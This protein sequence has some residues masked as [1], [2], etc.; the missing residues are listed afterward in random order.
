M[1]EDR[2]NV[3]P[4]FQNSAPHFTYINY[5]NNHQALCF[6]H[7]IPKYEIFKNFD[8]LVRNLFL[9]MKNSSVK[10]VKQVKLL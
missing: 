7:L 5:Q 1:A 10:Q 6:A 4:H 3:K 2:N 8:P 9:F